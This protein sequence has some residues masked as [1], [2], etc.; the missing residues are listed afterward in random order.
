MERKFFQLIGGALL[1]ITIFAY[2]ASTGFQEQPTQDDRYCAM[3]HM[4]KVS[5]GVNGWPAYRGEGV[6]K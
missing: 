3:V 1:A 4:W 6:C 2:G 5:G